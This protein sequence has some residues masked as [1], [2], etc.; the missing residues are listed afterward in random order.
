MK[1]IQEGPLHSKGAV[2]IRSFFE[3]NR[4]VGYDTLPEPLMVWRP[5]AG[6]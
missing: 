2:R 4:S 6:A 3:T 1:K 5:V